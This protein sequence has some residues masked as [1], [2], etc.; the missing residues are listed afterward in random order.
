MKRGRDKPCKQCGT[1]FY[2]PPCRDEGG[3]HVK[4]YFCSKACDVKYRASST[5]IQARFWS[6]V[7]KQEGGCWLYEKTLDADGYGYFR[8]GHRGGLRQWFAHRFSWTIANGDVPKGLCVCHTCDVRNCV[9]PAHLWIGT[10]D[11]NMK[12]MHR[13]GRG[14]FGRRPP[15]PQHSERKP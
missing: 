7:V 10:H 12:D 3:A 13:K 9:N 8:Y 4:K 5:G 6:Y 2:C 11:D 15:Q 1:P 14:S